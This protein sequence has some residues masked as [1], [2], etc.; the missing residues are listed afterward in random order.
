MG[1]LG[2]PGNA[3]GYSRRTWLGLLSRRRRSNRAHRVVVRIDPPKFPGP[4]GWFTMGDMD[5]PIA[6]VGTVDRPP[7]KG[8]PA[9]FDW[10]VAH[11]SSKPGW[12][13]HLI[14][15]AMFDPIPPLEPRPTSLLASLSDGDVLQL[16]RVEVP[17]RTY[18]DLIAKAPRGEAL[19]R[20]PDNIAEWIEVMHGGG[21]E[22]EVSVFASI[23]YFPPETALQL[24]ADLVVWCSPEEWVPQPIKF[25]FGRQT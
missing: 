22:V 23:P 18:P 1:L 5:T 9:R 2:L 17:G 10:L 20:V 21:F 12:E 16:E 11:A 3:V 24:L 13:R 4:A 19:G 8:A 6:D 7:D 25:S 15:S 14:P